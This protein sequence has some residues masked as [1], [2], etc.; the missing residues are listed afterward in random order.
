LSDSHSTVLGHHFTELEQQ[1][2]ANTMGMW[3]FLLTE[4]MFF[5]G[6]FLSYIVMRTA[7][8]DVFREASQRLDITLG[9]IN[10]AVLLCSSLTMVLAVHAAQLGKRKQVVA[11][12]LATMLLGSIFLGIK[13]VEYYHKYEDHLIPGASFMYE[14]EAD[15]RVAQMF[16]GM[17]F[18]M[19]GMHALHMVIGILVLAYFAV[20]AWRNRYPP[21]GY[22]PLEMMALYWHFVDIIWVFLFPLLYLIG[23]H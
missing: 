16:F 19:T 6:L 8:P 10:T 20:G 2:E 23:R 12:I 18:T 11:F 17:Y 22:T 1:H 9:T 3:V 14:G 15:P 7:Y 5:G 13:G 21:E 4:V